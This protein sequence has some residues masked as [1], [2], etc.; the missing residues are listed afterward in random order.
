M[1]DRFAYRLKCRKMYNPG[2]ILILLE[3]GEG[4]V[5]IA[6][7]DL[8]VLD[9]FAGDLFDTLQDP[10]GRADIVIDADDFKPAGNQVH[11][12]VRANITTTAGDK[13]LL[14]SYCLSC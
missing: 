11:Y 7:I 4:I 10:G 6:Q 13:D 2:N 5:V 1:F 12:R 8:I 3:D 9:L 14:H